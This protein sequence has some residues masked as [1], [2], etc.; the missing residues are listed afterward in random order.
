ML[1]EVQFAAKTGITSLWNET[2]ALA[3]EDPEAAAPE[4]DEEQPRK[5]A[6][7]AD[8][9]IA[10]T[11]RMGNVPSMTEWVGVIASSGAG[12]G[13]SDHEFVLRWT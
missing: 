7:Q 10:K 12:P 6:A 3:H 13:R 9:T 11:G 2:E 4:E 1:L 8:A 5:S